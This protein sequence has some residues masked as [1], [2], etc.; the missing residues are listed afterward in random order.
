M[1]APIFE[2]FKFSG[3]RKRCRNF[4]AF[5][6]EEFSAL[7]S[8]NKETDGKKPAQSGKFETFKDIKLSL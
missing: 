4:I 7:P 1:K 6:E 2:S 5:G 8:K 3:F